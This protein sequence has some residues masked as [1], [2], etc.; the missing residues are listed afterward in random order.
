[1]T[2]LWRIAGE[3]RAYRAEDMS[4]AGAAKFPGRWNDEG[5]RV[6]YT[7]TSLALAALETA[8]YVDAHGLPLNR[9]VVSI[10]VPASVWKARIQLAVA[11][12]PGGWDAV[13][14]GLASVRIGAQ[15]L[16][17]GD[18][19]ILL[20]P[21]VIVPEEYNA[22]INPEHRDAKKLR[23]TAGRKFQYNVVFRAP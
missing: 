23:A 12:L 2:K 19:A 15:W 14:A 7:A 13:P 17:G 10:E 22:L 9:H 21:S 6:L 16:R 11:D 20:V 3:T 1:M 5:Q 4:G 8:A 18:S